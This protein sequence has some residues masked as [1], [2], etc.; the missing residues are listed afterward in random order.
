L[1]SLLSLLLRIH[2]LARVRRLRRIVRVH[3]LRVVLLRGVLL[4]LRLHQRVV[5]VLLRVL[6]RCRVP[7][8]L[9]AHRIPRVRLRREVLAAIHRLLRSQGAVSKVLGVLREEVLRCR[10]LCAYAIVGWKPLPPCAM[11]CPPGKCAKCG[12]RCAGNC[13]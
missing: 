11:A 8:V 6:V 5:H 4:V 9:R 12:A 13:C 2:L 10:R 7:A 3:L 1:L